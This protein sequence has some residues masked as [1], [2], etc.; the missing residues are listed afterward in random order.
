MKHFKKVMYIG[1]GLLPLL[2]YIFIILSTFRTG[3][4]IE[5]EAVSFYALQFHETFIGS[6]LSDSEVI[7]AFMTWVSTLVGMLGG[8][9]IIGLLVVYYLVE[10]I[11]IELV[12]LVVDIALWIPRK[13]KYIL[14]VKELD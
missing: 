5:P 4:I 10:V 7:Q 3:T 12:F 1:F 2:P 13:L 8:N 14:S 9:G 6:A 11:L